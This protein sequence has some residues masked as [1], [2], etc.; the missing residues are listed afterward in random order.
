MDYWP[1]VDLKAHDSFEDLL[2]KHRR[3]FM[4]T[5][6]AKKNITRFSIRMKTIFMFGKE[7]AGIPAEILNKY[8]DT[9][10]RIP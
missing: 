5:T 8:R 1:L 3:Y 7:S 6:K 4:A 10:V 9:C 2:K